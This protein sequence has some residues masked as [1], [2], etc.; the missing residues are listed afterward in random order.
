MLSLKCYLDSHVVYKSLQ[1]RTHDRDRNMYQE[2]GAMAC[3][4]NPSYLEVE[5]WKMVIQDQAG[6]QW[7][8]FHLNQQARHGGTHGCP[9]YVGGHR[10][11]NHGLRMLWEKH[12]TLLK[13][14]K[15]KKGLGGVA[16]MV[17]ELASKHKVLSSNPST[18][19]RK[20]ASGSH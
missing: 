19:K 12:E 14:N 8:R 16:W 6:K 18:I 17:E 20:Y 10:L 3:A 7:A 4:C 13:N 1:F 9:C 5:I 11:E 2:L 15:S